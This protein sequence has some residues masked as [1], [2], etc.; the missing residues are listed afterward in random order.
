MSSST[1]A[2]DKNDHDESVP[3]KSSNS[4]SINNNAHTDLLLIVDW[5]LIIN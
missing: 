4:Q 3:T 5:M 2:M 1:D